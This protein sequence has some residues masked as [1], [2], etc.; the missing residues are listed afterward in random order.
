MLQIVSHRLVHV[1][2]RDIQI[3]LYSNQLF[4]GLSDIVYTVLQ[5]KRKYRSTYLKLFY[6]YMYTKLYLH[7]APLRHG[8]VWVSHGVRSDVAKSS[9]HKGH[10]KGASKESCT[11]LL[12]LTARGIHKHTDLKE[13]MT[14]KMMII[15]TST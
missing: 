9:C 5:H 12:K 1:R 11:P 10:K 4:Q 15:F 13:D 14:H 3:I 7:E 6:M 8:E 2:T